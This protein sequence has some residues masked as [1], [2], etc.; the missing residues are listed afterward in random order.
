M[1]AWLVLPGR[2]PEEIEVHRSAN[3][4]T[5][6]SARFFGG[7]TMD[8]TKGRYRGKLCHIAVD[9]EGHDKGL[10]RN[11]IATEAYLANC[12]PGTTHF[13]VGPAVIFDGLLP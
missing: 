1:K 4:L 2:Q 13:I 12:Y 6:V 9:D 5:F 11:D 3:T 8:M 10:A 7:A